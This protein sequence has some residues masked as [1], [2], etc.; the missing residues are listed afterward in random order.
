MYCYIYYIAIHKNGRCF[1]IRTCI[2]SN[3]CILHLHV[4]ILSTLLHTTLTCTYSQYT[5]A[6][7]SYTIRL[8]SN[9]NQLFPIIIRNDNITYTYIHV[10][11]CIKCIHTCIYVHTY[12]HIHVHTG[13]FLPQPE[14]LG[15]CWRICLLT[16]FSCCLRFFSFLLRA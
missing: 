6:Y 8:L 13:V 5:P 2:L 4:H 10:A 11:T 7:Y 12:V 9:I 1:S 14:F 15:R 16:A 3:S